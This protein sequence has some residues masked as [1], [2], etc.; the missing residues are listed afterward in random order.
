MLRNIRD[1]ILHR[2]SS[3][4][5]KHTLRDW[6]SI[7]ASLAAGAKDSALTSE[8]V[9]RVAEL[10]YTDRELWQTTK[11]HFTEL[12]RGVL[13]DCRSLVG[14]EMIEPLLDVMRN[15]C[16]RAFFPKVNQRQKSSVTR[17]L[18]HLILATR[19]ALPENQRGIVS[20]IAQ[21]AAVSPDQ[22]V[23]VLEG[24]KSNDLQHALA[25]ARV[26]LPEKE[27]N[28]VVLLAEISKLPEEEVR[29]ALATSKGNDLQHALALAR[30][31]LP[32]N[33]RDNVTLLAKISKLSDEEVRSALA[34]SKAMDL[35][36]SLAL[37]RVGLPENE[38]DNVTLLAKISKLSDEEV[39]SAL[40]TASSRD[41][42]C[43]LDELRRKI[44]PGRRDNDEELR[45]LSDLTPERFDKAL[46]TI[47]KR[48]A[49]FKDSVKPG[50]S[51]PVISKKPPSARASK[52]TNILCM[53]P[54]HK[55]RQGTHPRKR[56]CAKCNGNVQSSRGLCSHHKDGCQARDCTGCMRRYACLECS[57]CRCQGIGR[58]LMHMCHSCSPE[59][60]CQ[61]GLHKHA[62]KKRKGTYQCT[63][64]A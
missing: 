42:T 60:F 24:A 19:R 4:P 49:H 61:H 43:K 15:T 17:E 28:N 41:D 55:T 32:E 51:K 7:G 1:T 36:H 57:G 16:K 58:K 5:F 3:G 20:A 56:D 62:D 47:R 64:W 63:C 27:R 44:S 30:V 48:D 54:A 2:E 46:A 40:V 18:R 13:S 11:Q 14:D 37:A 31:G 53:D 12:L 23:S 6:R 52:K 50:I 45:T 10:G 22:V 59:N 9:N 39:R 21:A 38:R 26:G 8:Y 29:S 34:T 33:E 35:Q 25:L